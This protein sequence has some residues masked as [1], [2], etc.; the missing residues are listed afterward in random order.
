LPPTTAATLLHPAYLDGAFQLLA[1]LA[2]R[3]QQ[4]APSRPADLPAFLPVRIARL[5][6]LQPHAQVTAALAAVSE[7]R[8]RSRRSLR[9]DF[10]LYDA[11]GGAIAIAHGVRFRAVGIHGTAAPSPRWIA[12]RAVPMPRRDTPD[13]VAMPDS[14]ELARRCAARLHTPARLAARQR[15]SLEIEPLVD[16][17][18]ASLAARA[19]HALT[20]DQPIDLQALVAAGGIAASSAPM[21]QNLLQMLAE[22]GLMQ[23]I[24]GQWFVAYRCSP[25]R[26]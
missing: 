11:A 25:A 18:C 9:A 5:E 23:C 8:R 10:T 12:T 16:A 4:T 15:Y 22:D 17:L 24:G 7:P 3:E 2:L 6:L 14:A 26:T 13:A 20:G 19:V 21:L 1:D